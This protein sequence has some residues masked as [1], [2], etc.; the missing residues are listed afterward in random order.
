[1]KYLL[2]TL[3]LSAF[4]YTTNG[5]IKI[6]N[7]SG[8]IEPYFSTI[9]KVQDN[10]P[11]YYYDQSGKFGFAAGVV[12]N[13]KSKSKLSTSIEAGITNYGYKTKHFI[14]IEDTAS[15]SVSEEWSNYSLTAFRIG[16]GEK[17]DLLKNKLSLYLGI[18]ASIPLGNGKEEATLLILQQANK[19]II[20]KTNKHPEGI[21]ESQLNAVVN[22]STP[23]SNKLSVGILTEYGL[24]YINN[25]H[26]GDFFARQMKFGVQIKYSIKQY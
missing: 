22:F 8:Y 12:I 4:V 1:M 7:I 5:Q 15:Q 23:I 17:I 6:N 25:Y 13:I 9:R 18:N 14:K 10:V 19:L 11:S 2:T 16:I 3:F 20:D 21:N 26:A 24:S